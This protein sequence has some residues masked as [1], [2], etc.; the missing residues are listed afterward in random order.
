LPARTIRNQKQLT[1]KELFVFKDK[2]TALFLDDPVYPL[3][4]DKKTKKSLNK[5]DS[6]NLS[7]AVQNKSKIIENVKNIKINL[8]WSIKKKKKHRGKPMLL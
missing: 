3:E 6:I 2:K 7:E 5:Y 4:P 8:I 1:K